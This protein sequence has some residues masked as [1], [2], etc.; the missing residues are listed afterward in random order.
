VAD[1]AATLRRHQRV[2]L[3]TPVFI[4]HIE[5]TARFA[6]PAGVALDEL[7][8]GAFAGVTSVLTLLEIAVKPLQLGRPD[9]AEEYEVLLAN[10]PNLAVTAIDRPT[11]H[12]AAEL[13]ATHRLRPADALQLAA[14][15]E[16]GATAFLTND[17]ELQR[18]SELQVLILE[19][20]L[21]RHF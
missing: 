12:R 21:A 4:Y 11:A 1:L 16:Q 2:G 13:R 7:A 10:Y 15:L 18:I 3:D 20:F 19:D 5:G 6:E 8:G 9:V 14:C 17:R